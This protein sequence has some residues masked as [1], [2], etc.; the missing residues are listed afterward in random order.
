MRLF[1][2]YSVWWLDV[3]INGQRYRFS[4]DTTDKREAKGLANKRISEIEQGKFT[5]SGQSFSKLEFGEAADRYLDGR[6]L[7]LAAVT[8]VKEKQLLVKLREFFQASPL[9]RITA[10]KVLAYREWRAAQRV[11]P[12]IVNMKVGVLR[13]ILKRAKRWHAIADDIKPLR[14]P[15]S[16]GRA[17]TPEQKL[18]LLEVASQRPE[19]ETAYW[20]A[21]LALNTT[22]RGCELK[23]LLWQDVSF[24][25]RAL[26]IRKSKTE[27]G[28]RII[29]LT[30]EALSVLSEIHKRALLFG[31][32]EPQHYVFAGFKSVARFNGNQIVETRIS[33]FDPTRPISSWRTAWRKLTKKA[34]L[35]GLR[36]H[37]LR[38]HAIT[39]L[40]ESGA[41]DQTIMAIAG[42]V[43]RRMLDR[44]SHIRMEA[45]RK[46]LEALSGR[47]PEGY[48]TV[49]GTVAEKIPVYSDLN[50]LESMKEGIGACGF[51]PQTP[52]VSSWTRHLQ[53]LQLTQ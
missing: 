32:V 11:G 5:K 30:D 9:N 41:S 46:A 13:R 40:G 6:R 7:E 48:G 20:A 50:P 53:P 14:E 31:A 45:K 34:G 28:E 29:P 2:R 4:L 49:N 38:H 8:L 39:E 36:F 12:A 26:T 51:E 18:R 21:I 1:K 37:D 19:W 44:Y 35:P 16:I 22:M 42:H 33:Q 43:S 25:E 15:R 24:S 17:L 52:T 23:G 27:A 10:E 47:K 3:S